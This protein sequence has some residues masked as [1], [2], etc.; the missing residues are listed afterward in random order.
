MRRESWTH[1]GLRVIIAGDSEVCLS[2]LLTY[3]YLNRSMVA[4]IMYQLDSCICRDAMQEN[5]MSMADGLIMRSLMNFP[6]GLELHIGV[7]PLPLSP[8]RPG[9]PTSDV[10]CHKPGALAASRI[11]MP[12]NDVDAA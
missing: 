1:T 9:L 2:V 10:C 11:I 3:E 4:S 7:H 8:S 6:G 5:N 12:C